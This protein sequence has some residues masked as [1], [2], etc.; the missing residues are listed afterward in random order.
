MTDDKMNA[1]KNTGAILLDKTDSR[2]AMLLDLY[3]KGPGVAWICHKA[4][5]I[6]ENPPRM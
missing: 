5:S 1:V 4:I 3:N 6:P 2:L